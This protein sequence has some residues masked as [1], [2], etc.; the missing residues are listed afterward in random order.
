MNLL[1]SVAKPLGVGYALTVAIALAA[2]RK[3]QYFPTAEMPP[4][5]RLYDPSTYEAIEEHEVVAADGTRLQLWH[6]PA[7][8]DGEQ[9]RAWRY[10]GEATAGSLLP[11]MR[12]LR[13]AHPNLRS[14]DVLQFHGNAGSRQHRLPFM[15]LLREGLGC[16]VTVVDYRGYGGSEGTPTERGLI[17]DGAAAYAWLRQRQR[18][19][20]SSGVGSASQRRR[21]VLWG[22]SIGSGVA[23]ALLADRGDGN[24][25]ANAGANEGGQGGG[26]TPVA[27][28]GSILVLEAGFTSCVDLGSAAYPWLPVRL[29]MLD[30][31]ESKSRAEQMAADGGKGV[32]VLSLHG[33]LD[34]IAP[35]H[36]GRQLFDALPSP[37][38]RFVELEATGHND[39]PFK[40]PARYLREV[41][42]FL[43]EE[44]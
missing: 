4:H 1:A 23:V 26:D 30:R 28:D 21:P 25:G 27:S 3:L 20:R 31:F 16:S 6:W 7:P 29:G 39:V 38:K 43:G 34:D 44:V 17:Q 5:P 40:D 37:R 13:A 33:T 10:L 19:A 32:P 14:L 11:L 36:L 41:A 22:E 9:P 42:T 15:H 35:I 12:E 18:P 2:Q 24:A 8:A